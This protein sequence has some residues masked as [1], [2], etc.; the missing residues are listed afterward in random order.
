MIFNSIVAHALPRVFVVWAALGAASVGLSGCQLLAA[1]VAGAMTLANAVDQRSQNRHAKRIWDDERARVKTL[2]ANGDPMGD[3]LYAV[4]NAEGWIQDTSD[5][6]RIVE[7]LRKAADKGSDDATIV[8]GL[9]Y[10]N[11]V[12]PLGIKAKRLPE[13]RVDRV[14][15]EKLIRAGVARHCAYSEPRAGRDAVRLVDI[16]AARWMVMVYTNGYE[17]M[18]RSGN[19]KMSIPK[20]P[21]LEQAWREIDDRCRAAGFVD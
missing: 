9:Y 10:F 6:V 21:V 15:G 5:P 13:D 20:N 17:E 16:S 12:M 4:G 3:Y 8:L 1:P 14:L 2:Q 11:A 7:L 18:T 19:R